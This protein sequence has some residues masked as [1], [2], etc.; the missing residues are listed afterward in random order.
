MAIRVLLADDHEMVREAFAAFLEKEGFV[1]AGQARDGRE[2]VKLAAELAPD[3]IVL[4]LIMP[5]LNGL[6]AARGILHR[7]PATRIILVTQYA[8]RA[9]VLEALTLGVRGY[10]LKSQ[11]PPD[12]LQAIRDVIR[13]STYISPVISE[14]VVEAYRN[15]SDAGAEPL[16][17]RER[18]VL[19][20]IAEGKTNKEIAQILDLSLKT[21][22]SHRSHL[23]DKLNV[24]GTAGLVRYAVRRGIIRP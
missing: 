17:P 18:E 1:I 22:D 14:M 12:L 13:G 21:V 8:D 3:I 19:Q 11:A 2:V 23:M 10:V 20:L 6:D 15:K 4:D 16:S 5:E 7:D 9:Y 24:R